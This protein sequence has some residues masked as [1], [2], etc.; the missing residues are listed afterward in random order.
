MIDVYGHIFYAFLLAGMI[1]I[2]F[3]L[4]VGWW[5]R[6]IG[7]LGWVGLGF[8]LGLSSIVV[9]GLLFIAIDLV[10]AYRWATDE[11]R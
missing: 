4:R 11:N 9:W 2:A 5:L 3:G 7:E 10:G 1:C 6:V 8:V